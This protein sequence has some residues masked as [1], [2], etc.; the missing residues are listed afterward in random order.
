MLATVLMVSVV[1][2]MQVVVV[3]EEAVT[4]ASARCPTLAAACFRLLVE[5]VE[6]LSLQV[7]LVSQDVLVLRSLWCSHDDTEMAYL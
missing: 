4:S 1:L 5:Q 7:L 3:V 6:H 2:V